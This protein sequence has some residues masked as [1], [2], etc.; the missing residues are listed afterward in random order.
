MPYVKPLNIPFKAG[1][2][3][4]ERC[5]IKAH[6]LT[7]LTRKAAWSRV[8]NTEWKPACVQEEMAGSVQCQAMSWTI[9][10]A[11]L[12][13]LN[14]CNH[15]M[16][17]IIQTW[18]C[19]YVCTLSRSASSRAWDPAGEDG[20]KHGSRGSLWVHSTALAMC[21]RKLNLQVGRED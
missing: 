15:K 7:C 21:Y 3:P 20:I 2:H 11:Q 6:S 10:C 16:A 5:Y 8:E 14:F 4:D 19:Y 9:C 17:L 13:Y 12:I 1:T 18:C